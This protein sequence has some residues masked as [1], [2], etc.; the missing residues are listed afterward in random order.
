M[1]AIVTRTSWSVA[2]A[3]SESEAGAEGSVLQKRRRERRTY[4]FDR[5]SMSSAIGVAAL[6]GS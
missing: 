5:S 3:A 6:S 2:W 1:V 4:Q